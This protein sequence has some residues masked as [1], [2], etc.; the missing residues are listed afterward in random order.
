MTECIAGGKCTKRLVQNMDSQTSSKGEQ[1]KQRI[2]REAARL[3]TV[4]GYHN[5]SMNDIIEAT[6]VKKGNL[7]FHFPCK[8]DLIRALILAAKK[9]Y[10]QYLLKSIRGDRPFQRIASL[11]DAVRRFH[12][13]YGFVGGCVFGNMALEM[14]DE[15]PVMAGLVSGVFDQWAALIRTMVVEAAEAGEIRDSVDPDSASRLIIAALE[16]A[17]MM[18]KLS[19]KDEDFREIG[20]TLLALL[21][22]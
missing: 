21:A 14:G 7:Y 9:E 5:T 22:K 12:R 2:L 16:G 15:D 1:T 6:G 18:A 11:V 17:V 19:K 10:G 20:D 8:D 4:K 3:I 13:G